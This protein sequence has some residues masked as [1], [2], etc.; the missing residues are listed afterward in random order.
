MHFSVVISPFLTKSYVPDSNSVKSGAHAHVTI[1]QLTTELNV[2]LPLLRQRI[3]L[4]AQWEPKI[5]TGCRYL[6]S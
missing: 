2:F 5:E 4:A 3:L 6:F 1:F